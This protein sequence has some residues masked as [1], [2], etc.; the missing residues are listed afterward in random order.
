MGEDQRQSIPRWGH[1][2][3]VLWAA[4]LALL[5]AVGGYLGSVQ[6]HEYKAETERARA[7]WLAGAD[8]DGTAPGAGPA[9]GSAPVGV[10][11]GVHVNRLDDIG[12]KETSWTADFEIRFRWVGDRVQ[13]GENFQL[14]NGEIL[15]REKK[16]TS[17]RNGERVER[18]HVI[19]RIQKSIDPSRFPFS[20]EGLA[21]QL[22]DRI[23]GA[24]A[25]RY[26]ADRDGG[27][28][29][30]RA[31]PRNLTVTR[32]LVVIRQQRPGAEAEDA[33]PSPA[34]GGAVHSRFILAMVVAPSHFSVF[35]AMFQA[36]FASVAIALVPLFIK[37]TWVDPRFGLGVG[38]F[39]A[40]VANNVFLGA[41]V[42]V[43]ARITLTGMINA[44]GLVTIFLTLAQSTVSLYLFDSLGRE[45]LSRRF[46]MVSFVVLLL[47]YTALM[48]AMPL[49]AKP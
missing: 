42:P 44:I 5:Y 4:G 35:V 41:L 46:D 43:A 22:Q 21:I 8:P 11:V 32:S 29:S 48:L 45:R 23:H 33:G 18:Y 28:I 38:A 20:D 14:V 16:E 26:V 47:G 31:L 36:L 37:P 3:L 13:P 10:D 7:A 24:D 19:A 9:Q 49:A 2:L 25:L 39:F 12:L 15:R 30:R 6:L 40:A 17:V 27:G 34:R 1:Q